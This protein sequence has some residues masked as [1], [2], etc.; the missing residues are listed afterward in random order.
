MAHNSN[1]GRSISTYGIPRPHARG[2]RPQVWKV[3]PDPLTHRQYLVW[4]QQRNQA[5]YREEGW[6]IEFEAW[7]QMWDES[8]HWQDRGR[9]KGTWCMTRRDWSTPWTVENAIIVT[10]EVHARMQG[11]AVAQ[12]WRSVAQK[13]RRNRLGKSE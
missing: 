6:T 5:N 4:L 7:K 12:G 1:K 3:G 10:R 13:K 9:V 2:P 11:D 8:G